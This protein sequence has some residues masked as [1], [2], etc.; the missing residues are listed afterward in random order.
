MRFRYLI[1]AILIF[2]GL[3]FFISSIRHFGEPFPPKEIKTNLATEEG[4]KY[5]FA[6]KI[7]LFKPDYDYEIKENSVRLQKTGRGKSLM[8]F[9]FRIPRAKYE[10]IKLEI[11]AEAKGEILPDSIHFK[12]GLSDVQGE[13]GPWWHSYFWVSDTK[14][15]FKIEFTKDNVLIEGF[16]KEK[17]SDLE[18]METIPLLE[19]KKELLDYIVVQTY[20]RLRGSPSNITLVIKARIISLE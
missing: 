10:K 13:K 15:K 7:V 19:T 6:P 8:E 4:I 1:I 16:P 9:G 3:I 20:S 17:M 5:T 18:I 14:A 12:F 11:E 2:V